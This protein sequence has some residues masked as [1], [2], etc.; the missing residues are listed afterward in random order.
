[1]TYTRR[2]SLQGWGICDVPYT[3]HVY[4]KVDGKNKPV[5]ICPYYRKWSGIIKRV[6][7]EDELK[8]YPSYSGCTIS[9]SWKNLSEFIK[10]V[11]S[12]PNKD[13][14]NCHLDKDLLV[15]GNKHYGP[16]TCVFI[17]PAVNGFIIDCKATRGDYLLGTTYRPE[18]GIYQAKCS[19][20]FNLNREHNR[21]LGAFPTELE[22]HKAW[23]AKKHEYACQLADLQDDPR[24]ADALRQ[25]Y[26]PDKDWTKS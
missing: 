15:I 1:M 5:W 12:Q 16:E 14:Q 9:E 24:V 25:R 18:R 26:A 13:W 20:A 6:L 7:S 19:N 3:V 10:W 4:E 2:K 21:Y 8:K 23:Q 22:A 17:T 11:D